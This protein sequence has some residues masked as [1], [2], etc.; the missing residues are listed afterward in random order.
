[1]NFSGYDAYLLYIAIKAHFTTKGYDVVKSSGKINASTKSYEARN[2]R[3]LFEKLS[4]R[5]SSKKDYVQYVVAN[6][7]YGNAELLYAEEKSKYNYKLWKRRKESLT[8]IFTQ[9][10]STLPQ[11]PTIQELFKKYLG[12]NIAIETLVILN[13]LNN[14]DFTEIDLY[15]LYKEN[16]LVIN[17][18]N[19]FIKIDEDKYRTLYEQQRF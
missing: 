11:C 1:M 10:L 14:Y 19:T 16:I 6:Y 18:L 4:T 5:F 2:D 15:E 12:D 7:A 17:K 8:Y 9:D 3:Y 13:Q